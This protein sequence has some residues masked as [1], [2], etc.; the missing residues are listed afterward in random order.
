M[1]LY[2]PSYRLRKSDVSAK[3][4]GSI[5]NQLKLAIFLLEKFGF[6]LYKNVAKA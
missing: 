2:I 5:R 4:G 3:D 1:K 6:T